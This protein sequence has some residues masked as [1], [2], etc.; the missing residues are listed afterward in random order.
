MI[1]KLLI[2]GGD[3]KPGPAIAQQLGPM[4]IN[5]GKVIS[6]VN[7]A[8]KDF[9]GVKVPVEL[10]INEKTKEFI[11]RTF[12]PPTSELLKKELNLE[13]GSNDHKN[14]IV[15]NASIE[16]IIRITK[17]KYPNMLEKNFKNAIKSVLGT[18]ASIG[19]LVENKNPNELIKEVAN[20]KYDNEIEKQLTETSSEK[21]KMINDY[22]TQ[23]KSTQDAKAEAAKK[24]AEAAEAAKAAEATAAATPAA[25]TETGKAAAPA[26]GKAATPAAATAAAAKAPAGKA[27][28]AKKEAKKK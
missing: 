1:I 6:S 26:T 21:R 22:Y 13:K 16:D 19:I 24:A 25:A 14:L 7:A 4:G 12:S 11:I 9:K 27:A 18:C 23:I 15:G 10:D 28:P 17:I 8:T 5:M 2:D 20:G 3:M